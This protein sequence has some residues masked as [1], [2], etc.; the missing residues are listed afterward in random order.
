MRSLASPMIEARARAPK[1]SSLYSYLQDRYIDFIL[2]FRPDPTFD[3]MFDG[4]GTERMIPGI[5][6]LRKAVVFV[7]IFWRNTW[8]PWHKTEAFHQL[9][10]A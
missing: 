2:D 3:Q 1:A 10:E 9:I 8:S 7:L 6:P 4:I 5:L